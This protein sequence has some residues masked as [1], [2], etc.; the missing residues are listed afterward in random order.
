[1]DMNKSAAP[2]A[3]EMSNLGNETAANQNIMGGVAAL[4]LGGGLAALLYA[5]HKQEQELKAKKQLQAK[6]E[7]DLSINL[8]PTAQ[9]LLKQSGIFDVGE[10]F[11]SVQDSVGRI[12]GVTPMLSDSIH[13]NML[14]GAVVGLPVAAMSAIALR[15]HIDG[16]YNPE[17]NEERLKRY[18][19]QYRKVLMNDLRGPNNSS[20]RKA[21]AFVDAIEKQALNQNSIT[22]Y[23]LPPVAAIA[24]MLGYSYGHNMFDKSD[25]DKIKQEAARDAMSRFKGMKSPSVEVVLTDPNKEDHFEELDTIGTN[26][27]PLVAGDKNPARRIQRKFAGFVESLE[28]KAQ[29]YGTSLAEVIALLDTMRLEDQHEKKAASNAFYTQ[30][31]NGNISV[32]PQGMHELLTK[33]QNSVLLNQALQKMTPELLKNGLIKT[34]DPEE[35]YQYLTDLFKDPEQGAGS[36]LVPSWLAPN[37]AARGGIMKGINEH[38]NQQTIGG[39]IARKMFK[40]TLDDGQTDPGAGAGDFLSSISTPQLLAG[41]GL[42]G[43][44]MMTGHPILGALGG[45]AAMLLPWL[46]QKYGPQLM[47]WISGA[48]G[49]SNRVA[50]QYVRGAN[51]KVEAPSQNPDGGINFDNV[52]HKEMGNAVRANVAGDQE[53]AQTA[54]LNAEIAR[55]RLAS[56]DV[57][58]MRQQEIGPV[59]P[60]ANPSGLVP[61]QADG[62]VE[63]PKPAWNPALLKPPT[64]LQQS[65][66]TTQAQPQQSA[67]LGTHA[68][69]P[70]TNPGHPLSPTQ[71]PSVLPNNNVELGK[72]LNSGSLKAASLA[73]KA[74]AMLTAIEAL[75]TLKT[76]R[77]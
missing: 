31:A 66:A 1:M 13:P 38:L 75:N 65:T 62:Q 52:E 49:G 43:G 25:E 21:A 61:R 40:G 71:G 64:Q 10:G 73:K 15:N 69:Q 3:Y 58:E 42:L 6:V 22:D 20:L 7:S 39:D 76:I 56:T 36:S 23:V 41:L 51:G 30:D 37:D 44:G 24:A 60:T 47:S 70:L 32:T 27:V 53:G 67:S 29:S 63:I 33:H 74:Q 19:D 46:Y 26:V 17:N 48:A 4:S 59:N 54:L 68:T 8:N 45:G 5:R 11:K 77:A 9:P 50:P 14:T 12:L 2:D 28:K 18:K 34:E 72:D 35:A 55:R 16:L 57:S